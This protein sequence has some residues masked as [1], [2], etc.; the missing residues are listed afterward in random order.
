MLATGLKGRK[1]GAGSGFY[2]YTHDG[3]VL[4]VA[5]AEMAPKPAAMDAKAIQDRLNGVMID[6]T[7]RVLAEGV[8]KGPDDADVAL[9]LGAGFPAFRG[10]LMRHAQ[11]AGLFAG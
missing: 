4:N 8:L 1:N 5:L 3:V 11:A 6:E 10:G 9:L 7:K 2:V